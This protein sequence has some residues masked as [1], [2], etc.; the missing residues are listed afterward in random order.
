MD[1]IP[2]RN[3]VAGD[4]AA[5]ARVFH[6]AVREGALAYTEAQRAAWS[7][8]VKGLADWSLR[9]TRQD[10]WVAEGA[11]ANGEYAPVGFMTLEM[12]DYLDCAYILPGW[13]GRGLFRRLYGALEARALEAGSRRP[14]AGGFTHMRACMRGQLSERWG[15]T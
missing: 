12:N 9:M 7:P 5:L 11:V 1:D 8:D 2:I 10:V 4:W 3:G 14:G 15:S 13:Q 6:S